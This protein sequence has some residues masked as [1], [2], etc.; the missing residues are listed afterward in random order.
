LAYP[1]AECKD[2]G[3]RD[4]DGRLPYSAD[5]LCAPDE[6]KKKN[7]QVAYSSSGFAGHGRSSPHPTERP[8]QSANNGGAARQQQRDEVYTEVS[9]PGKQKQPRSCVNNARSGKDLSKEK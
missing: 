5:R 1:R 9:S 2:P 3:E 6:R 7:Q 4:A 8:G